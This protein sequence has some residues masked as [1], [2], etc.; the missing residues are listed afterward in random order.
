MPLSLRLHT[1]IFCAAVKGAGSSL[2]LGLHD[3]D[4]RRTARRMILAASELLRRM[5]AF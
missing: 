2:E 3:V 4:A 1:S 5:P